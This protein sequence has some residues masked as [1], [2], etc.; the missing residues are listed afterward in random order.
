MKRH[1]AQ[2]SASRA[3]P[4]HPSLAHDRL[5]PRHSPKVIWTQNQNDH[6]EFRSTDERHSLSR[7][8]LLTGID[9]P[10]TMGGGA[11]VG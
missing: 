1:W 4:Q 11:G 6:G 5:F 3:D 10:T 7:H 9:R 8:C 2:G